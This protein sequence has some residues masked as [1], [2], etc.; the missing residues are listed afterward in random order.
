MDNNRWGITEYGFLRPSYTDLLD[1]YEIKA[2]QLFGTSVNLSVRSPLGI[3]LRIFAWFSSIGWQ[4]AEDVYNSAYVDTA[5]GVNLSRLGQYIGIRR[6]SAQKATGVLTISGD[7]DAV[8]PAGFLVQTQESI[9]FVTTSD[10]VIGSSGYVDVPIQ[11]F[12]AGESGN[13]PADTIT[14]IVTPIASVIQVNNGTPTSGGQSRETDQQFRER[15]M[16]SVDKPGGSNTDAIRAAVI[17][18][19]G[20]VSAEVWENEL[21]TVNSVGMLPHSIEAIVLGGLPNDIANAIFRAKAAG[22][23]TNGDNTVNV[24]DASGM[25]KQVCFS[26][27]VII[28]IYI[29]IKDLITNRDY[30][31][32][33]AIKQALIRQ[34]G[35][36]T[37]S[38]TPGLTIGE[39]VVYNKLMCPI[40][41]VPGVIDYTV[42]ISVDNVNFHA[43]NIQLSARQ[44]AVTDA[45]KITFVQ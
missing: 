20:V 28:P 32:N 23:Q 8:V 12:D 3:F 11:A 26:R 45:A 17:E 31:G 33:E 34:I 37:E 44:K 16:Q 27:P 35:S 5:S 30:A 25:V 43:G 4:L 39:S 19:E 40:N 38:E 22:I 6:L 18:L 10:A 2:R 15:Y 14:I 9:R 21:D 41:S 13:V 7:A 36:S 1:S 42:E 29:R 24:T